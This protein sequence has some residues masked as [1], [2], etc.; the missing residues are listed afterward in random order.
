[1]MMIFKSKNNTYH[2]DINLRG[3]D[4]FFNTNT[5]NSNGNTITATRYLHTVRK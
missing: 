5:L 4:H 3:K 1:M 2:N